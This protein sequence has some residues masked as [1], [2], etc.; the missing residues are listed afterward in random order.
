[1]IALTAFWGAS[2][3][4]LCRSPKIKALA[5]VSLATGCLGGA[6]WAFLHLGLWLPLLPS[7]IALLGAT[8]LWHFIEYQQQEQLLFEKTLD[9][10]LGYCQDDPI[11]GR[12]ALEYLYQAETLSHQATIRIKAR[13]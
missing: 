11:P 4:W 13:L 5:L 12:I 10:L 6:Y 2:L 8:L 7:F 9:E 1:L 3:G